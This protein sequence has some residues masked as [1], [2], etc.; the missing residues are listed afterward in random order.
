MIARKTT[1]PIVVQIAH[2]NTNRGNR[3]KTYHARPWGSG[4]GGLRLGIGGPH[5]GHDLSMAERVHVVQLEILLS[6][7]AV[8]ISNIPGQH[9][10][11]LEGLC[12]AR[13]VPVYG[14]QDVQH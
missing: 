5:L 9:F 14:R 2:F 7:P 6:D 8:D 11:H 10:D 4:G 12:A 1:N 3:Q 13:V